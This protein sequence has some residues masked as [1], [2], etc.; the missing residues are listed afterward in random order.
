MQKPR[1]R[2]L[3]KGRFRV[4]DAWE[5]AILSNP[6]T[7]VRDVRGEKGGVEIEALLFICPAYFGTPRPARFPEISN[8]VKFEIHWNQTGQRFCA[9]KQHSIDDV[10]NSLSNF[11][12]RSRKLNRS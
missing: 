8:P 2:R 3:I 9:R 6:A 7:V 4:A 5:R 1:L 12:N 10:T 11:M